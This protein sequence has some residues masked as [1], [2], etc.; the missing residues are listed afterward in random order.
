M[1]FEAEEYFR[2]LY[3]AMVMHDGLLLYM[4]LHGDSKMLREIRN[5]L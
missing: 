2:V 4:L 5:K 1:C 3:L